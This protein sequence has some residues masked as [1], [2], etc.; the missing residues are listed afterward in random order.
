[1]KS[2]ASAG[3]V[4]TVNLSHSQKF[5]NHNM[6]VSSVRCLRR[7]FPIVTHYHLARTSVMAEGSRPNTAP[8]RA[9]ALTTQLLLDL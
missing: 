1:M 9:R 4:F 7:T 6:S 8:T 5:T 3:N 2:N